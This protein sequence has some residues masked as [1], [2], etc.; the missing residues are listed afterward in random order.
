MH[1]SVYFCIPA[2]R[3]LLS[4]ALV[5]SRVQMRRTEKS[6][7]K[8][9]PQQQIFYFFYNNLKGCELDDKSQGYERAQILQT[10]FPAFFAELT[11]ANLHAYCQI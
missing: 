5:L 10:R 11:R 4:G 1:I 3:H 7:V 8:I 6:P 9:Y 2:M